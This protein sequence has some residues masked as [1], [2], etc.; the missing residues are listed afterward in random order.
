MRLTL[1]HSKYASKRVV[2]TLTVERLHEYEEVGEPWRKQA[3]ALTEITGT[4]RSD[5]DT[6]VSLVG[7]GDIA[8]AGST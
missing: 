6:T 1:S 8:N 7:K 3:L 5:A 4:A 2:S